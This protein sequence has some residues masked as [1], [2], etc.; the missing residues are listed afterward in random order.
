MKCPNADAS[1]YKKLAKLA[2]KKHAGE[3]QEGLVGTRFLLNE[4]LSD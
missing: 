3:I 1:M 4:Q 2:Y